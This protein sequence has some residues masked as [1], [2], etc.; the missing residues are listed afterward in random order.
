MMKK[1][2]KSTI[3]SM[4]AIFWGAGAL[5]WLPDPSAAIADLPGM[6]FSPLCAAACVQQLLQYLRNRKE[7]CE[8]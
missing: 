8:G 2:K 6:I 7:M 5:A 1:L 4:C 3:N